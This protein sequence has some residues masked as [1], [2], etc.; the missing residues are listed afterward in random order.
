[1]GISCIYSNK[2][3]SK[4]VTMKKVEQLQFKNTSNKDIGFEIISLKA[5]FESTN[6]TILKKEFRTNFYTLM[7]I[8]KGKGTHEIDFIEYSINAGEF[9]IL[10]NNRVHRYSDYA[11]LEGYLVMFTEGFLCEYLSNQTTEVKDLFKHSYLNPS[12]NSMDLHASIATKLLDVMDDMYTNV[13]EIMNYKVIA[14]SFKTL[15]LL[16]LNSILEKENNKQ[17]KNEVFIQFTELVEQNIDKE[18]TV[19]GYA[20]MMHVSK[21]TINLMTRNAI[22]MSAKQYI[23][24]QLILKIKLKLCFEYK[25]IN[26]I[27][28]DLGFTEP[29]NMT[30][31]FKK[32]TGINPRDFRTENRNNDNWIKKGTIDL[33][34][35]KEGIE[36]NVYHISS[37]DVPLLHKHEGHDEIFYCVKGSGFGVYEDGEV[38]LNVGDSFIIPAGGMHSLR[39]DGDLY[40]TSFLIPLLD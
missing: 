16:I 17:K 23:I 21:K 24:Q 1:M 5:F 10:S 7:Y 22:D 39:S 25:S 15:S 35:V 30:R 26:E 4:G 38:N 12:V 6:N 11:G 14:S 18:K 19:E 9:L 34:F 13:N 20:N 3:S 32:Y 28:D 29:S 2:L 27:S 31:F 8:T 33:D 36:T 37:E 40:I